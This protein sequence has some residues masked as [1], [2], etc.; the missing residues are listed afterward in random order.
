MISPIEPIYKTGLKKQSNQNGY[1]QTR[2]PK[3]TFKD[4]LEKEISMGLG[5]K[6]SVRV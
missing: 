3:K 1:S 2:K 4:V 5:S 6:V